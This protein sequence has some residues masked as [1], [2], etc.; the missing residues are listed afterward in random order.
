M[1][2]KNA[3]TLKKKHD[4]ETYRERGI[5]GGD[6]QSGGGR[7]GGGSRDRA[8]DGGSRGGQTGRGP[9]ARAD[10]KEAV[11]EGRRALGSRVGADGAG[12][13]GGQSD[14]GSRGG[15]TGRGPTAWADGK[16]AVGEG[17]WAVH[18]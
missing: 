3:R 10:G 2:L 11:G 7:W 8:V 13:V 17:R 15:Q 1:S 6:G 14:G 9:S 18:G 12:A 5:L 16:E 4:S